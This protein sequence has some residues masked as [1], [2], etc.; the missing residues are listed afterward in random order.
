VGDI[1][2]AVTHDGRILRLEDALRDV[3]DVL[4]RGGTAVIDEFQRL[5]EIYWSL[6]ST[7][8]PPAGIHVV[9]S[10]YGIVNKFYERNS[11]LHS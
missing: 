11:P 5:P 10:S 1:Q 8:A 6:I 3:R 9:A 7:W 4:S 2:N